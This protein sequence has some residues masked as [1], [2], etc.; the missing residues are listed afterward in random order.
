MNALNCLLAFLVLAAVTLRLAHIS[1]Y[2]R[3]L[4]ARVTRTVW[5]GAHSLIGC[6]CFGYIAAQWVGV[7]PKISTSMLLTGMSVLLLVKWQRRQGE[8]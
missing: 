2:G 8:R 7:E 3:D 6:G 5:V 1:D 4:R